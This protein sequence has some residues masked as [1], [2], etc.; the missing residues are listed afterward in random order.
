MK[1]MKYEYSLKVPSEGPSDEFPQQLFSRRNKKNVSTVEF[2][3]LKHLWDH[4]NLFEI[5]IV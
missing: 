5:W 4:G 3:W 2:Q 1:I